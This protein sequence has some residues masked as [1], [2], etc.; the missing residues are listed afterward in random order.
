MIEDASV[1]WWWN[2]RRQCHGPSVY[3]V[4][5]LAALSAC[6]GAAQ[7][8]PAR[9][10]SLTTPTPG[11][12]A[13]CIVARVSDG[14]SIVCEGGVRVRLI[15]IDTPELAQRP[16]G[17]SARALTASLTP[18]GSHVTLEFDIELFDR[19][20]RLLAYVHNDSVFVNREIVRRGM[21]V[22]A[23]FPPNVARVKAIR[24]AADSARAERIGLWADG[25]DSCAPS[26]FR[27]GR[28]R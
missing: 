5:T 4:Y 7:E 18:V 1:K 25:V 17:D 2:R 9:I 12:S 10:G 28:C 19:Y 14:D 26:D 13:E 8:N 15:L 22:V 24:A 27:A 21:G 6:Q 3:W 11:G 20:N 16:Y 23:V